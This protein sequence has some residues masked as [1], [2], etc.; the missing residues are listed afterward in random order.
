MLKVLLLTFILL[1]L[2]VVFASIGVFF[3][4]E[5]IK[6]SCGGLSALGIEKACNCE[7]PC[8]AAKKRQAEQD[9]LARQTNSTADTNNSEGV[10]IYRASK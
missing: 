6:G 9:A 8:D 3:K 10:E 2:V 7:Q 1:V 4:R 5:P